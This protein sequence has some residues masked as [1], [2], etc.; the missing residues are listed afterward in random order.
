MNTFKVKQWVMTPFI[1]IAIKHP[2]VMRTWLFKKLMT[3]SPGKVS[4]NYD[5]MVIK[6]GL[7]YTE[8]LRKALNYL[9]EPYKNILEVASGT[10]I[11]TVVVASTFPQTPITGVDI[12]KEMNT[13]A[14]KKME[15]NGLKNTNF[16]Q[17]DAMALDFEDESF[18]L[19]TLSNAPIYLDELSRVLKSDGTLLLVF[20]FGKKAF[21]K[22]KVHINSLL[23]AYNMSF[24]NLLLTQTG[25]AIIANKTS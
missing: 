1:S 4:K 24:E 14:K 6:S 3:L 9:D 12:S 20:S 8:P 23:K 25:V 2:R 7:D 10:G 11:T 5:T 19:V 18:D 15:A 21:S 13:L 17:G 22:N 16:I